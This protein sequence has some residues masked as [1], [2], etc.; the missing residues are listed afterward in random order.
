MP[1]GSAGS[2]MD[3]A[4]LRDGEENEISRVVIGPGPVKVVDV[5]TA[6]YR[7]IQGLP[8]DAV[9]GAS[10]SATVVTNAGA[11]VELRALPEERFHTA[12]SNSSG[13]AL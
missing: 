8:D 1:F 2:N 6:W 3:S 7:P 12:K 5:M 4:M 10:I 9:H 11:E 13:Y